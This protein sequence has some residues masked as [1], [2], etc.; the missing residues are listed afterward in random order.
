MPYNLHALIVPPK[1]I[2]IE[3]RI[4]NYYYIFL[5]LYARMR[6]NTGC[7]ETTAGWQSD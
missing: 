6:V 3:H 2:S 1:M 4:N 5:Q 7:T